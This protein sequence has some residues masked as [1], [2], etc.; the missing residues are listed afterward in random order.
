VVSIPACHAGDRCS[1]PRRGEYFD[2]MSDFVNLSDF[3]IP[4]NRVVRNSGLPLLAPLYQP[5]QKDNYLDLATG[6]LTYCYVFLF[7]ISQLQ[8]VK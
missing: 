1:I 6:R 4:R 3:R 2:I 7:F 8:L 5:Q